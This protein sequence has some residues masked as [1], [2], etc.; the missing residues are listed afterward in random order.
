MR[1]H[2]L[3]SI[4]LSHFTKNYIQS[5]HSLDIKGLTSLKFI[6]NPVLLSFSSFTV[7]NFFLLL[8]YIPFHLYPFLYFSRGKKKKWNLLNFSSNTIIT[9]PPNSWLATF[10]VLNHFFTVSPAR[11]LLLS[12]SLPPQNL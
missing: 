11:S 4:L 7:S 12:T 2:S 10:L 6:Q 8:F 1:Q 5:K 9:Y 3:N